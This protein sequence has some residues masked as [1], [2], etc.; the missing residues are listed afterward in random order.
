MGRVVA[1]AG[2]NAVRIIVVKGTNVVT[3]Y[4]VIVP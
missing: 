3:A 4:P 1:T 2:E